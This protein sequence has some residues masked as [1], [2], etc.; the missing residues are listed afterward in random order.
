MLSLAGDGA[1]AGLAEAFRH[2]CELDVRALKPGNVGLHGGG[3]GMD[4]AEFM[5]SAAAAAGPIAD[6]H[7]TVGGRILAA[8][9]A[10]RAVVSCNTN[11]GI[12]LLCAPL[13]HAAQRTPAREGLRQGLVRSLACLTVDD[14]RDAYAAIRIAQPGGLGD[15]P[16]HDV[17]DEPAVTLA[18]AMAAASERDAIAAQYANGYADVFD[19]GLPTLR[20]ARSRW[21]SD[22]W[23][24]SAAYL[25]FAARL[26]DSHVIRRHGRG[27][28]LRVAACAAA[29]SRRLGAS[30]DPRGLAGP[31][32]AWDRK[33]KRA[34]INPGTSADL[35][36]AAALALRI[37][38]RMQDEFTA[39]GPAAGL[40]GNAMWD[41]AHDVS[42]N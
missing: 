4:V 12:V 34:G 9:R 21:H 10:T 19:I 40:R 38:D 36:V 41:E 17:R 5:A 14:A 1:G 7:A 29:L 31:L 8:I 2:A 23:G 37:E 20:R 11:L 15:A 39:A 13:L 35:T 3:H 25:E 42:T 27:T 24:A 22:A 33:L 18:A 30:A 28:A 32:L 6:P 26:P 16:R